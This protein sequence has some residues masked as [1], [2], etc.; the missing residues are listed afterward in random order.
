MAANATSRWPSGV[1]FMPSAKYISPSGAVHTSTVTN[2]ATGVPAGTTAGQ[3]VGPRVGDPHLEHVGGDAGG[4]YG[5]HEPEQCRRCRCCFERKAA[6]GRLGCYYKRQGEKIR[7]QVEFCVGNTFVVGKRVLE[8][9]VVK[10]KSAEKGAKCF[11]VGEK[12]HRED[13]GGY[14]VSR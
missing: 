14:P 9:R 4:G 3:E 12:R 7:H 5:K 13:T 8:R 1:S 2:S 10:A 6:A 11:K